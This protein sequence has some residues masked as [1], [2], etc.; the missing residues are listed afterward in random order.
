M[1]FVLLKRMSISNIL[2]DW[3]AIKLIII[4]TTSSC[5]WGEI[6]EFSCW[7]L[8]AYG[9]VAASIERSIGRVFDLF[10]I[11]SHDV[12]AEPNSPRPWNYLV[13]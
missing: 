4:I 1:K 3:C 12:I 6:D 8:I 10:T 11:E 5:L 7:Q 2:A 9:T 13:S